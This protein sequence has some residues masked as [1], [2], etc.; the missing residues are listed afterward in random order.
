[1]KSLKYALLVLIV[2]GA[3]LPSFAQQTAIENNIFGKK[4]KKKLETLQKKVPNFLGRKD[5][6]VG[7]WME[8]ELHSRSKT[9][10]SNEIDDQ[11]ILFRSEITKV[12]KDEVS[13]RMSFLGRI[14]EEVRPR[15]HFF[16][17][18]SI[19][20]SMSGAGIEI[21]RIK[22]KKAKHHETEEIDVLGKKMRCGKASVEMEMMLP[23]NG[24][25]M[26]ATI[27][28]WYH[29]SIPIE[30]IAKVVSNI[31]GKVMGE[32]FDVSITQTLTEYGPIGRR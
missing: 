1:M 8:Y 11:K 22:I 14:E 20:R 3:V 5:I 25:E 24:T 10:L 26:N 23:G 16:S 32:R 19:V 17:T 9:S 21:K 4:D 12:T 31:S 28:W 7:Q 27:I 2:V 30:G 6:E 18:E 13:F 15:E 29:E